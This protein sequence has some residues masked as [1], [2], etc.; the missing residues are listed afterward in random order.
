MTTEAE[1]QDYDE[2][3]DMDDGNVFWT[4]T[5]KPNTETELPQPN[6]DGYIVH[7]TSATFGDKVKKGSR[8]V[9]NCTTFADDNE[10]ITSPI[11]VLRENTCETIQLDLLFS[12]MVSFKVSGKNASEVTLN[13]YLQPP[14]DNINAADLEDMEEAKIEEALKRQQGLKRQRSEMSSDDIPINGDTNAD[15]TD[16]TQTKKDDDDDDEDE[17]EDEGEDNNDDDGDNEEENKETVS[18][19]SPKKRKLNPKEDKNKGMKTIKGGIKYKIMRAGTGKVLKNGDK[20]TVRYVGQLE[21][22]SVFDKAITG[23]G[24]TFTLGK[25]E[26]IKGWDI[27]LKGMKVGGKRR[28]IIPPKMAYG[29]KGSEPSIPPN[30]TLTFTVEVTKAQ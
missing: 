16:E 2:D 25:G 28:L 26:V 20:V 7:V 13:G 10:G 21:D 19:P 4:L 6:I 17:D 22:K 1:E 12:E 15:A 9:V 24:F 3:M 23:A 27:G 14:F 11:C 30:A 5:V 8:T 29:K 18:E